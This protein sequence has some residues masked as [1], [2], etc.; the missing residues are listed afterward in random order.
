MFFCLSVCLFVR[1]TFSLRLTVFLLP[2]SKVQCP[3]FLDIRNPWG[4]VMERNG[5]RFENFCS[6]SPRQKKKFHRFFLSLFT[7][8]KCLFA[9]LPEVQCHNL[10]DFWNP[11]GKRMKRSENFSH[12]ECKIAACIFFFF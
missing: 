9:P 5:L 2:L 11:W 3:N 4:K 7:M 12:K 6:K 1:H 10:L 8:F